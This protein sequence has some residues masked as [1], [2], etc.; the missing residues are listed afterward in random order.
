MFI[1]L[2][3]A[4]SDCTSAMPPVL[5]GSTPRRSSK[6]AALMDI[7]LGGG[8]LVRVDRE[9]DAAALCRVIE[10]LAPR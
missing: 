5:G 7:D 9:V 1:P 4:D 6:R 2:Q 10:A 8:R 3:I